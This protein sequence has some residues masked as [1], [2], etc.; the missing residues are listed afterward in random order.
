MRITSLG[1]LVALLASAG[2]AAAEEA[3]E[4]KLDSPKAKAIAVT[5]APHKPG[6]MTSNAARVYVYLDAGKET[7]T[8]ESGKSET[9]EFKAGDVRWVPAGTYKE[10]IVS[11]QPVR[12]VKVEPRRKP[13]YSQGSTKLDPTITDPSHYKTLFDNDQVRA[14]RIT[15]PPHSEGAMHE[16]LLDR[17]VVDLTRKDGVIVMPAAVRISGYNIHIDSNETDTPQERIAIELK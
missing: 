13:P 8:T 10:E 16:H 5:E 12:I 1:L 6:A 15:F 2:V 14:L 11:D 3:G 7:R 4:V 9:M 17:A